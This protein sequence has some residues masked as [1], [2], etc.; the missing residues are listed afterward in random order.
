MIDEVGTDG[1]WAFYDHN[2]SPGAYG[3]GELKRHQ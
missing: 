2:S 3:P 1:R